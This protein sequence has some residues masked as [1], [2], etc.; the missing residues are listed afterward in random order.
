MKTIHQLLVLCL[1]LC[2]LVGQARAHPQDAWAAQ[3]ETL[4]R[5]AEAVSRSDEETVESLTVVNGPRLNADRA[6]RVTVGYATF[7][8][9]EGGVVASPVVTSTD[10]GTFLFAVDV[11][12]VEEN[13]AWRV[14]RIVQG[15]ELPAAMRPSKLPEYAATVPVPFELVDAAT[16]EPVHARVSIV[17]A[18]GE[19]WPPDGHQKNIRTG[20][21]QDVG[22][23]VRIADQTYAYVAP[24]FVARLPQGTFTL[25]ARKGTEYLPARVEFEVGPD[26]PKQPV[27][28]AVARWIDMPARG[29]YAGDTHTHFL[30]DQSGLLEL[31]AEDLSVLY[32]LATKWGELITDVN[33]F[34]GKP[35]V[36]GGPDEVVVF[37]EESRHGWIGHTILHRIRELVYPL[38]WGGPSEGVIGGYDYP[39]M[40]HQ[41]DKTHAQGGLVTW[42]HFPFPGGELA[43]DI[44]LGKIDT[45][46]LF[47]WGDAFGPG[48]TLSD[49]TVLPG[50]VETWYQFL[51][52][53]ARLPATAG[54]DKMLNVQVAGSVKTYAYTGR[55][56]SYERWLDALEAGRTLVST[57]PVVTFTANGKP[58]GS[59]LKLESGEP[60]TLKAELSAP[61][62]QYPVDVLE[63]VVGGKVVASA[64]NSEREAQLS[65]TVTVEPQQSTWA[66]ARAHGS[67][68]LPYQVWEFLNS[69]GIPPMAHTSP[70]YLTVDGA[71]VWVAEDAQSL[72][73]R[74]DFAIDWARSQARYRSEDQRREILALFE[75]ARSYYARGPE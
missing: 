52:T 25:E 58:I 40:A 1:G 2:L 53:N 36:L 56:F 45:V 15:A 13:G 73:R 41:A 55:R 22:G 4:S 12:L 32:I 67:K 64:A 59:E 31:R 63:I 37:N 18:E 42:A 39:A 54:T 33:R 72:T 23:D 28:V 44:G 14:G 60:V 57:G 27:R 46:D 7:T 24:E 29:W 71:P 47:T 11:V 43:V 8:P 66:A 65:L 21:R 49:G 10:R 19:Y 17:D 34:T 75:K 38:T 20:W 70:I 30:D 9:T 50:A 26:G 48:P 74:V 51:N 69:T 16:G 5:W 61:Y 62:D 35:G 6:T 68:E 3:F